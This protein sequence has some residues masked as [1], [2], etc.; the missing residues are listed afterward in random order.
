MRCRDGHDESHLARD[1]GVGWIRATSTGCHRSPSGDG[2]GD[3]CGQSMTRDPLPSPSMLLSRLH[4]IVE[5]WWKRKAAEKRVVENRGLQ[6]PEQKE[7]KM[8][9]DR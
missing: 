8:V 9:M 7:M 5:V 4:R 3:G 1:R 2:D 6:Q